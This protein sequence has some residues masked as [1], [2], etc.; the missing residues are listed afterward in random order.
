MRIDAIREKHGADAD[1]EI[2]GRILLGRCAS[3][4]GLAVKR[5]ALPLD[6]ILE[7]LPGQAAG[8]LPP[9]AASP[10][11]WPNDPFPA[12]AGRYA[13]LRDVLAGRLD[14]ER[15]IT[16]ITDAGLRGMGGAG[17]PAGRKWNIVRNYPAPRVMA[18][19]ID[20]GEPGTFKDRELMLRMPH[21]VVE[22]L[23]LAGLLTGAA[24]GFIYVRHEYQEEIH[25]I[26]AEIE[27]AKRLGA[28]GAN[29]F[30]TDR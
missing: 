21:L 22:G 6:A 24:A 14:T 2:V 30:D 11:R 19:N 12:A 29:V 8:A 15:L 26:E 20:E 7:N 16:E 13:V 18:V 3:P 5:A 25:A 10:A 9:V 23:I 1:S 17:F 4:R 27:R 28:C